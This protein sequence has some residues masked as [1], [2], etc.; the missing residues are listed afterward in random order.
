MNDNELAELVEQTREKHEENK[1]EQREF[2][3][4]LSEEEGSPVLEAK[5]NLVGDYTVT[6]KAKLNGR[7]MDK[8]SA[9]DERLERVDSGDERLYK[10]SE[11]ADDTAQ[12]LDDLIV[13]SDYNKELFYSAYHQEGLDILGEFIKEVLEGLQ[14][15]RERKQGTA[16]G[17]RKDE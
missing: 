8:L 15:A 1:K 6:A 9:I 5:V 16:D 17:F 2:L 11:A 7:L 4:T 13:E 10:A 3:E 14:T 12:L